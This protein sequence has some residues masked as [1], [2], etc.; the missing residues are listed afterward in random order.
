EAGDDVRA[1][2]NGGQLQVFLD[3][4]I[5]VVEGF[6]Q[7]RRARGEN[8]PQLGKVE[9]LARLEAGFLQR[10]DVL[11]AGAEDAD[12]FLFRV[13]PQALRAGVERRAVVEHHGGADGEAGD[14]PVPHHPAAG[15]EVEDAVVAMQV[16]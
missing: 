7:Q 5:D 14:Q 16:G 3:V 12:T 15:R 9:L 6:R 11:R 4:A 2:G 10:G 8:R 13:L 1:A